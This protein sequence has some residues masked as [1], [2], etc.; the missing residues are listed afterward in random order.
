MTRTRKKVSL[1]GLES[2]QVS[3]SPDELRTAGIKVGDKIEVEAEKDRIV[4]YRISQGEE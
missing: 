4:I 1:S 2:G 3:L